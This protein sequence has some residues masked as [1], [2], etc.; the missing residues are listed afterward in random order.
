MTHRNAIVCLTR[1]YS[2]PRRYSSLIER[3][4]SIYETINRHRTHQYPLIIWH[5]GNI[6]PEHQHY[7]ASRELNVD[8]R[9]VDISRVFRLPDG[10]KESDL[11]EDWSTGYR[12]M[13][14]F[15]TYYIWQY[16]RQFDYVMRLDED[17]TF[18]S[19]A[20]DPI[21]SLSGIRGDFAAADF[22]P[23]T[24]ELT[25]RTLAPFARKFAAA[26]HPRVRL[27]SPYNH[28]FPYTNLYVTRT[29][30]WRQPEIQRFLYAVIRERN[31]VRFRWGDL[32]VMGVALNMFAAPGKLYR[33]SQIGY[34]HASHG[35]TLTPAH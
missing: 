16:T 13:C 29:A 22:V 35:Y 3:N 27:A 12:L 25:N 2:D 32:P 14:R 18:T 8:L 23:E 11:V 26:V 19:V 10:L 31:S 28:N 20:V 24:H 5:Q 6:P 9:F 30:F 17:C 33:I 4:R 15:H 1:G 21:E 34:R 7:I